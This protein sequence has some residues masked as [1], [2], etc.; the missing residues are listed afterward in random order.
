VELIVDLDSP[1]PVYEQLR[2]QITELVESRALPPD[3]ALPSIRSL[4]ADLGVAPGTV[5]RAYRELEEA[6]MVACSRARGTRVLDVP[7]LR[8]DERMVRLTEAVTRMVATARRLGA[9]DEEVGEALARALI[10]VS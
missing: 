1:I 6:G 3:Y 5:A 4:A 7:A 8:A 2:S 9:S 10:A